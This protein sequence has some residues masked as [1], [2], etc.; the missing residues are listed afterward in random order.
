M[1]NLALEW[2]VVIIWAINIIAGGYIFYLFM[3][4]INNTFPK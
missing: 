2:V 3:V 4:R 1:N